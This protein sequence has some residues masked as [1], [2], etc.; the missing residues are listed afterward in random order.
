MSLY[1]VRLSS[2]ALIVSS[3][4]RTISVSLSAAVLLSAAMVAVYV[5]RPSSVII[6]TSVVETAHHPTMVYNSVLT[7]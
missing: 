7:S 6:L 3:S 2:P 4:S 5:Q 1:V